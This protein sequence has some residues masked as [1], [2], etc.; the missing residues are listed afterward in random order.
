MMS[1][2]ITDLIEKTESGNG[3]A[4]IELKGI[5]W[6]TKEELKVLEIY[7]PYNDITHRFYMTR[8]LYCKEIIK[9][10]EGVLNDKM[11]Y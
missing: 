3:F 11:Y 8:K 5:L 9:S 10:I 6:A 7:Y 2:Y 4:T 1:E